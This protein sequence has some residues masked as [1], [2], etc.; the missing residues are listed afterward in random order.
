MT[1]GIAMATWNRPG[2]R[3]VSYLDRALRSVAAQTFTDWRLFL[4]GD[5]FE[6]QEELERIVAGS[7]IARSKCVLLNLAE[8]GERGKL[9]GPELYC[10]AGATAMSRGLAACRDAGLS[11]CAHLDDDDIWH[12]CHLAAIAQGIAFDPDAPLVHTQAQNRGSAYFPVLPDR[13]LPHKWDMD[14]VANVIHSSTALNVRKVDWGYAVGGLGGSDAKMW[15][16]I[17]NKFGRGSIT[18]VPIMT[19]FHLEEAGSG[20]HDAMHAVTT[21]APTAATAAGAG[22]GRVSEDAHAIYALFA[23]SPSSVTPDILARLVPGAIVRVKLDR[24]PST[25]FRPAACNALLDLASDE[26]RN[27]FWDGV[28]NGPGEALFTAGRV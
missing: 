19:V 7:G 5:C 22:W 2:R 1:L 17:Q 20:E 16:A 18:H 27:G 12:P 15:E 23:D 4:V 9:S 28:F 25:G 14:L 8:P 26:S 24:C 10:S 21:A 6:P 3:T 13:F 11:W